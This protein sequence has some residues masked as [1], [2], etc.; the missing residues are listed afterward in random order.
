MTYWLE[1]IAYRVLPRVRLGRALADRE[2]RT[3]R[4]AAEVIGEG[5]PLAVPPERVADNV[6]RF[7][8]RGESKRA[9]RCRVLLLLV[10]EIARVTHGAPFSE[11]SLAKRRDLVATHFVASHHVYG[12]CAKVRYLVI[13]GS[14]GDE[15]VMAKP[16]PHVVRRLE[17]RGATRVALSLTGS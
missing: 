8:A 14:Y 4:A 17:K 16:V 3:L 7:L 13:M 12:I 9:W 1:E 5:S 11:L 10:E 2:W 15:S 6:E